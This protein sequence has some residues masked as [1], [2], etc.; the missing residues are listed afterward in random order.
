MGNCNWPQVQSRSNASITHSDM[1]PPT[2]K[3]PSEQGPWRP[4]SSCILGKTAAAKHGHF[5]SPLQE[6]LRSHS[7]GLQ[8]GGQA[9]MGA[10]TW[11]SPCL[12]IKA[13]DVTTYCFR[14]SSRI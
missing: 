4:A 8:K 10:W 13:L 1:K 3:E 14:F 2:G 5:L 9:I 11:L 6:A 7:T 12:Q